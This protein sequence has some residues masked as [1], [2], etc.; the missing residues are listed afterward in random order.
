MPTFTQDAK[1]NVAVLNR[2]LRKEAWYNTFF[3]KLAGFMDIKDT[4]GIKQYNP[5]PNSVIQMM[6][7]F[8]AEGRDNMIMPMELDLIDPGVYG[9][10]ALLG[11]GE[12]L[13]MKYL[14]I[15]INQKRKAVTKLSGKMSNQRVKIYNLMERAKPALVKWWSKNLNQDCFQTIYEGASPHLT[16]GTND[17]GIGLSVRFNPNWYYH[18]TTDGTITTVGTEKYTKTQTNLTSD[19]TSA[20]I[21]AASAKMFNALNELITSVLLIEP[22]VTK[23]GDPFW[24]M[25]VHP[26][27]FKKLK[28]DSTIRTDQNAAFTSELM[29]HPAINGRNILYYDGFC[30]IPDPVGVRLTVTAATDHVLSLAGGDLRGGWLKPSPAA[31][32]ISNNI[33]LGRNAL[34]MGVANQLSFTE[35]VT[36]HGNVIEIGSSTIMGHN[37]SDFFSESDSANA[38]AKSNAT[39]TVLTTAYEAVNQ[40]SM[41]I[42]TED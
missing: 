15:Y 16:A 20:K 35:E 38:F 30:I 23:G 2:E 42:A 1:L 9:D 28:Q 4:N 18:S 10:S 12:D 29:K 24:I 36:D 37:R 26:R 34:G 7:E 3:S 17:D 14:Q 32:T 5:A 31:Y 41:I 19:L 27:T 21:G 11:T 13:R 6:R 8:V 40:S 39:K 25:L 33:I 22:L